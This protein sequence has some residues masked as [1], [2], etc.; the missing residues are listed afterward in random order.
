[1]NSSYYANLPAGI[2]PPGVKPNFANPYSI[3]PVIIILSAVFTSLMVIVVGM[4][5]FSKAFVI[6]KLG[7]DDRE[8]SCLVWWF[9]DVVWRVETDVYE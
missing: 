3:A 7:A 1:M 6:R 8:S 5:L 9:I 4:R 2:P